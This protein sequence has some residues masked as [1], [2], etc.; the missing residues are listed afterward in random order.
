[1][2]SSSNLS[3][4][5]TG[6]GRGAAA[7]AQPPPEGQGQQGVNSARGNSTSRSA[8]STSK[9][10]NSS[11]R[12]SKVSSAT[13]RG[14]NGGGLQ[15]D[16]TFISQLLGAEGSSDEEEGIGDL[17]ISEQQ[18]EQGDSAGLVGGPSTLADCSI[19][20]EAR[21]PTVPGEGEGE[22]DGEDSNNVL[23]QPPIED[24]SSSLN[25]SLDICDLDG[26]ALL[27][28]GLGSMSRAQTERYLYINIYI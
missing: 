15:Q 2:S 26:S 9:N 10:P 14:G 7:A 19:F 6:S 8:V 16:A 5:S 24:I 11:R 22:G 18:Q 17:V 27:H 20:T 1:M 25:P 4:R 13:P 23:V 21:D 12:P 28:K 3:A